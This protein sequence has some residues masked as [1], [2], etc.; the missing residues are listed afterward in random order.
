MLVAVDDESRPQEGNLPISRLPRTIEELGQYNVILMMDPNPEEF[1]AQWIEALQ[2]FCKNKAG[3]VLFMA[4]PQYTSEFVTLNR[5]KG[6]R[7]ILPVRVGDMQF[8][9]SADALMLTA[10]SN[11]ASMSLVR[12][13][14]DHPVL[15]FHSDPGE[16]ERRW[17][18]M[19]G[20]YWLSLIHI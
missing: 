11:K 2:L 6:I 16:N 5:L 3:G 19:P 8:I 14:L 15:S 18:A 13:N 10:S 9:D 1:D 12:H 17:A 7:D 20:V 4:G